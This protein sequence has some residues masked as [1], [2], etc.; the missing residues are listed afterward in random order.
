MNTIIFDLK[1]DIS[2]QL[3]EFHVEVYELAGIDG[4]DLSISTV[5][6]NEV[7]E[8][9]IELL[10]LVKN[11]G[12]EDIEDE[13]EV[14]IEVEVEND[15][16]DPCEDEI[17]ELDSGDNIYVLCTIDISDYTE[18]FEDTGIDI[19]LEGEVDSDEDIDELRESN[20]ELDWERTFNSNHITAE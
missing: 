14:Y 7:T 13:F 5:L 20:N 18:E 10:I 12:T 17:D 9:E 2:E 3:D 19:E 4:S 15:D 11:L 1:D 16:L 6:I 8:D